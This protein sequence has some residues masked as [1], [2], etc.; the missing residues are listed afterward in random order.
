ME[1]Q[2]PLSEDR[3]RFPEASSI[4]AIDVCDCSVPLFTSKEAEARLPFAELFP[5]DYRS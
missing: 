2:E 1:T 3:K 5:A 4:C